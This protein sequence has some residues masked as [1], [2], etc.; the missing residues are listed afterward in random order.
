[1][2]T[3]EVDWRRGVVVSVVGLINEV[4]QRGPT[5]MSGSPFPRNRAKPD[6]TEQLL[7]SNMLQKVS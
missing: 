6:E 7:L 3:L 2:V 4:N 1:M 5:W